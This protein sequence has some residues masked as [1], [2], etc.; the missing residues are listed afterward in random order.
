MYTFHLKSSQKTKLLIAL[1]GLTLRS[2]ASEIGISHSFLSQVLN[3]KRKPSAVVVKKIADGLGREMVDI[4][5]VK[6]VD[7]LPLEEVV[8]K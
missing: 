3:E 8:K 7:E 4:F 6:T 5:L 2:F 1:K